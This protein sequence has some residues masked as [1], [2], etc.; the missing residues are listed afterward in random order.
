[1]QEKKQVSRL[2]FAFQVSHE[3]DLPEIQ[4]KAFQIGITEWL[5]HIS[6]PEDINARAWQ[7]KQE[8]QSKR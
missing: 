8:N 2:T 7:D 3:T 5:S 4:F 1:M 6:D